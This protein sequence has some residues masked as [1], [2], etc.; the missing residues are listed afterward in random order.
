[1]TRIQPGNVAWEGTP[2]EAPPPPIVS[3]K[4]ATL[5]LSFVVLNNYCIHTCYDSVKI[6]KHVSVNDYWINKRPSSL[7]CG[8]GPCGTTPHN[9]TLQLIIS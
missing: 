3:Y 4:T 6:D 2:A 9:T 7:L 1:M 5:I 8:S